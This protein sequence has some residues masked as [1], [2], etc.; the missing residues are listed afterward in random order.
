MCK[1]LCLVLLE[2]QRLKKK[3]YSPC[4]LGIDS[5]AQE[6]TYIQIIDN[7]DKWQ[8]FVNSITEVKP[9]CCGRPT[10]SLET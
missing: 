6:M 10:S 2:T 1:A 7:N 4:L 5:R 3:R 9:M 8:H